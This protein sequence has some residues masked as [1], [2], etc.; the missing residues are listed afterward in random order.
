MNIR[1]LE[2]KNLKIVYKNDLY[3]MSKVIFLSIIFYF[4]TTT[5]IVINGLIPSAS[6]QPTL[7]IGDRILANRLSYINSEPSYG[8]IVIFKNSELED[9]LIV[10][11][12]A[13]VGGDKVEI[14][15]GILY[16]N[17]TKVEEDYVQYNLVKSFGPYFVPDNEYFVMGDNRSASHDSRFLEYPF[18]KKSQI[19][20]KVFMKFN[21]KN[22]NIELFI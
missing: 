22:F 19:K 18:I 6:M 16:I 2:I 9:K 20:G 21:F 4:F 3:M 15:D 7:N 11:R 12:I 13:A 1:D 14:E 17:G 10:K 8:D 5:F